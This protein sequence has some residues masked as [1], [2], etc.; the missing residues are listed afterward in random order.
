MSL[1]ALSIAELRR[2]IAAGEVTPLEACDAALAQIDARDRDVHAFLD[3]HAERARERART[4][5]GFGEVEDVA[6]RRRARRHQGQHVR[7]RHH[8]HLRLEDPWGLPTALHRDGRGA[9]ARRGCDRDREDE[10]GRICD[11]IVDGELRVRSHTQPVGCLTGTRRIE[12]WIGGRGFGGN[13][14]G[15]TRQRYRRLDSSAGRAVRCGRC[16]AHLRARVTLRIGRVRELARSDRPLRAQRR[17]CRAHSQ[18]D[19]RPGRD[20]R[21]QCERPCAGFHR[22]VG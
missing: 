11:G 17:R 8:D 22:Q 3:V 4:L 20:G 19:L 5:D 16:Q 14:G 7:R 10:P 12:R 18:C 2:R 13:G 1:H 15:G 21:E 6:A 9:L